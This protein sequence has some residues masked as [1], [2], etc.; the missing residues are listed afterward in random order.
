MLHRPEF[1]TKT[2]TAPG[3]CHDQRGEPN[4]EVPKFEWH[5]VPT[6]RIGAATDAIVKQLRCG[7]FRN[8]PRATGLIWFIFRQET[9]QSGL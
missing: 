8:F 4:C 5:D 7:D 1:L 9:D 3:R 6:P 2:I